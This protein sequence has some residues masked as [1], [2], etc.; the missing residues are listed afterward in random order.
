M[1]LLGSLREVLPVLS[2][3]ESWVYFVLCVFFASCFIFPCSFLSNFYIQKRYFTSRDDDDDARPSSAWM[4]NSVALPDDAP[5][6]VSRGPSATPRPPT[7]IER[8]QTQNFA[9]IGRG[10]YQ[11]DQGGYPQG[12]YPQDQGGYAHNG[13]PQDNNMGYSGY[14]D[15]PYG[16]QPM[17]SFSPG[18]HIGPS[19]QQPFF[20]PIASPASPAAPSF[21]ESMPP[22]QHASLDGAMGAP[23]YFSR[24]SSNMSGAQPN[25][26]A[27]LHD[28]P[29][30]YD[31]PNPHASTGPDGYAALDRGSVTAYQAQQYAAISRQL[32]SPDRPD[33]ITEKAAA[34]PVPGTP[35]IR[36]HS[37]FEDPAT[38]A[39]A[40]AAPAPTPG[41]EEY[42]ELTVPTAVHRSPRV[43]SSPPMLPPMRSMSPVG[44]VGA[45]PSIIQIASAFPPTP[46]SPTFPS[47]AA[48]PGSPKASSFKQ[49]PPLSP[50]PGAQGQV[51]TVPAAAHVGRET[52]LQFGFNEPGAVG[53]ASS[54]SPAK[55]MSIASKKSVAK[56]ERPETLY[57]E[58]DAYG[59]I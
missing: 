3:L 15:S 5:L 25:L 50:A 21:D 34:I 46:M 58:E 16:V 1:A 49:A 29:N 19:A 54:P 39:V 56:S 2:Y 13:Y 18:Q 26:S 8:K 20:S 55:R 57:D 22:V 41:E 4:R 43:D 30:P 44:T 11:Y 27:N 32:G 36:E 33:S 40:A 53:S 47:P 10:G 9:N 6:P 17:P 7:M 35:S 28:V 31:V 14:Q 52:P 38:V 12:G 42:Q 51:V 59:G 45:R 23:V 37:P 48:Q 24:R